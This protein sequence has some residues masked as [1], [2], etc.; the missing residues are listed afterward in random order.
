M[1]YS[2]MIKILCLLLVTIFLFSTNSFALTVTRN[3]INDES[4]NIVE[5]IKKSKINTFY[6][7]D[8]VIDPLVDSKNVTVTIKEI[9]ALD[10]IDLF[11]D[12][13]FFVKVFINDFEDTSDIWYNQKY[14]NETWSV[15]QDV[16]N[17]E[18][19][20]SIKIQLWDWNLL[21][22]KLCD[23]SGNSRSD[24]NSYDV[25]LVYSLKTG[26]WRGDDSIDPQSI[27]FD[28]SGYGRLNGCD[29]N[30]IYE[31]DRDCEVWFDIT[32]NDYDGD[33]IPYWTEVN[34]YGTD[35]ED[36]DTGRDY[37]DDGVPIEWEHK[38]GVYYHPW[39]KKPIW[40]YHPSK[41]EDHANLDP[42]MD[43][44]DNIEEY[45]T[46]QWGSDPFRKDIFLEIDQMEIKY[47]EGEALGAF[48]PDLS[49][50]L[51]R[52]A[53]SKHNIVFHIDDGCMGGGE[54]IPFDYNTSWAELQE[55]YFKYF[56][57]TNT[58]YWRRGVFHYGLII[59]CFGDITANAFSTTADGTNYST[60]SFQIST[61]FHET[62]TR[63][64]PII[65]ILKRKSFNKKYQRAV[66]YAGVIM[67]ETG[68]TLGIYG[69]NVPG[70][71][72]R[73]AVFPLKYWWE[74]RNYQSCMNY[75]CVYSL[76]D[77]SDGLRGKNDFDD[78][79]NIDLTLFQS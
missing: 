4:R 30:S 54:L 77:Y 18:E 17:D 9:R 7:N 28:R 64:N 36:D 56:L 53:Y 60:D 67:H 78:W 6:S 55:F 59:Y 63:A 58:S 45:L 5:S 27:Q 24:P 43:G 57:N 71:D 20:V 39:R 41:Q 16:P 76:V 37:D 8:E 22:D 42:D 21:R 47:E 10:K 65:N 19:N 15:T 73:N 48:I 69:G 79:A 40:I 74:F 25:E 75:N 2:V 31:N 12:P 13:D 70:C 38:W 44:L 14:V 35:P 23:I 52:D 68:H 49:K 66:V 1:K 51:L 33:G 11:S 46:S 34:V 3:T 62:R 50:D 29:D 26:H 32:Q 72:N 61:K